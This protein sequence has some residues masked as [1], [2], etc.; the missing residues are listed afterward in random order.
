MAVAKPPYPVSGETVLT[1]WG[2][3]MVQY[4]SERMRFVRNPTAGAW[5]P[6]FPVTGAQTQR[7]IELTELPA[8][9]PRIVMAQVAIMVRGDTDNDNMSCGFYDYAAD[10]ATAV[11]R[12]T[13]YNTGHGGN[14]GMSGSVPIRVGGVNNRQIVYYTNGDDTWVKVLGWWMSEDDTT[15]QPPK[16]IEGDPI[17]AG[18]G[19]SLTEQAG[20]HWEFIAVGFTG[21]ANAVDGSVAT[22]IEA[23][24]IPANDPDI[25]AV[26]V[27]LMIRD[28]DSGGNFNIAAYDF[29]PANPTVQGTQAGLSYT[30]GIANRGGNA[31]PFIVFVGGVNNRQFWW[32]S[33]DTTSG[34]DCWV[35]VNGYYKAAKP[36]AASL[37]V[38][39]EPGE[40]ISSAWAIDL[41]ETAARKLRHV[42]VANTPVA[43]GI[44]GQTVMQVLELTNLPANDPTIK[45]AEVAAMIRDN[46]GTGSQVIYLCHYD[47]ESIAGPAYSSGMQNRGGENGPFVVRVGGVNNRQIKWYSSEGGTGV[48]VWIYCGGYYVEE[49]A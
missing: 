39:P 33:S 24:N 43:N 26:S 44:D 42:S 20:G 7:H 27:S 17:V 18:W 49:G 21:I 5:A 45:Y 1:E 12:L 8:N 10:A 16:P 13:K 47:D 15:P 31:G 36:G 25:V 30:E 4:V 38:A 37:P 34:V 48:D 11:S 2:T 29:N 46:N 3:D 41:I 9:D 22:L 23:T 35:W 6:G 19:K 14:G 40:P 28:V 32:A